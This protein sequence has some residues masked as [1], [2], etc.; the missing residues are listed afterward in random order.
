M[1]NGGL[2]MTHDS[3]DTSKKHF[4]QLD[5]L[6]GLA[7]LAVVLHHWHIFWLLTPHSRWVAFA[8]QLLP[9]RL[10]IAGHSAVMMF[11][12]LSGFVLSLPQVTG[13]CINYR[14]YGIKRVCRIY[15]P[16][17]VALCL[18]LLGCWKWHGR[19]A[20]GAWVDGVWPH[21]PQWKPVIQHILFL[22]LYNPTQYNIAFWTLVQEMRI[23]L[24][25]PFVCAFVLR[26]RFRQ[27][28][29]IAFTLFALALGVDKIRGFPDSFSQ[30]IGY[31]GMFI[32][33][34]LLARYWRHLESIM[35][36]LKRPTYWAIAILGIFLYAYIPSLLN[37]AGYENAA[38]DS[39]TAI[40]AAVIILFSLIHKPTETWL[41]QRP[42]IYLGK[43]SYSMYLIHAPILFAFGYLFYKK[44]T[45]TFW[46]I[47]YLATTIILAVAMYHTVELPSI[48]LGRALARRM[49]SNR[50]S[51]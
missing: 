11:F 36:M 8:F 43:I 5:S 17:I 10:F 46:L 41:V 24:I 27:G 16:Y 6:R 31:T 2:G 22:G 32:F 3:S 44:S 48:R 19:H 34:I 26:F 4:Y 20:Y 37:Y 35:N 28:I 38:W 21:A 30:T 13:K 42:I 9:F 23:S 50:F 14:S 7:A 49:T 12:V 1:H 40:G 15:L 45:P 33:G 39:F 18:A 51:K 25:F 47:P 29:L